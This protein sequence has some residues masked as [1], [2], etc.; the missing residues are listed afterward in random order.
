MK[1]YIFIT[2]EGNSPECITADLKIPLHDAH[3]LFIQNR[4]QGITI[5]I[6]HGNSTLAKTLLKDHRFQGVA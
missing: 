5:N 6:L 3:G 1:C 2:Q 4:K